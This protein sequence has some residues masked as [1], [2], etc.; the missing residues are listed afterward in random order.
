MET[1]IP[2]A[3]VMGGRT[4][5]DATLAS[6]AYINVTWEA[7]RRSYLDNFVPFALEV[8]RIGRSAMSPSDI[9]MEILERFGLDFPAPVV[10]GLT[11]RAVKERQVVRVPRS[12]LVELAP[13][14]AAKLADVGAQQRD[15]QR[16]QG[17]LI[18][19][20][21]EFAQTRFSLQW[22]PDAA[23]EALLA[24]VEAHAVPL[25][26]TT[27]RGRNY[28]SAEDDNQGRGFVVAAFIAHI[29][30]AD[31][32]AFD[33]LD[34]MVKGSMLAAA[35]YV[36]A[37]GQVQRKFKATKLFLDTPICLRLLGH[38]GS[39]AREA[40]QSLV[41]IAL[42]EGAHLACFTHTVKEMRGILQGAKGALRRAP[43]AESAPRGVASHYR[44]SGATA[45][46]LDLALANLERDLERHRVKVQDTP[47]HSSYLGVDESALERA[48]QKHV[49][50]KQ[51]TTLL[52]DLNS[53]TAIHRL[54]GGN[55]TSHL[56]TCRAVLI[57]NN[58]NVVRASREFF[59]SGAHE[60]PLVMLDSTVATLLWV[61]AP[62]Q[63]P[64]LPRRQIIAD[65][66]SALAPSSSLWS[67]FSEEIDRLDQRGEID[68]ESVA[69]LRYSHEAEQALMEVTLG[70]PRKVTEGAIKTALA[71]ARETAAE[72]ATKAREAALERANRAE[73]GEVESR[74]EAET[75]RAQARDLAERVAALEDRNK[76]QESRIRQR[77]EHRVNIA[78][79][80]MKA[81][82]ILVVVASVVVGACSIFPGTES[83]LPK[84]AWLALRIAAAIALVL[85]GVTLWRGQSIREWVERG[86]DRSVQRALQRAQ[87]TALRS[88]GD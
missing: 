27:V 1:P 5:S 12:E 10:K 84:S 3:E 69:L 33:Y 85:G 62:T 36:D 68:A 30:E 11:D 71:K 26:A 15:F 37:T 48:L 24:Y 47:P 19:S 78:V 49:R 18:A 32:V 86:G 52:P 80:A 25:L 6:L 31:P 51:Q 76:K 44:D 39:E 35:L 82:S 59:D 67:R 74:F 22:D 17:S 46:D 57:T 87:L 64:D 53:L 34:Q 55:S 28:T 20:L 21:V 8:L 65:C 23:E 13:G 41:S 9:R 60:W 29:L 58:H 77:I 50:Y 75:E 16:R 88:E 54:R 7:S 42:A 2:G 63:A 40:V 56:E 73:A 61:K 38:E 45:A 43:G 4:N 66:Y 79:R 72:P 83:A 70:D 81:V 14:V